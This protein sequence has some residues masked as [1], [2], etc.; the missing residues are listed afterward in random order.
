MLKGLIK[1]SFSD[2]IVIV[3]G[4]RTPIGSFMGRL[5]TYHAADLGS[6]AI[7]GSLLAAKVSKEEVDEVIMG[8]VLSSGLGQAPARQAAIRAGL[9]PSVICTTINK[10]CASGMKS[11]HFGSLSIL[12]GDSKVVVAGG[13]ESMSLVPHYLYI[14]KA[15]PWGEP[16]MVDGIMFDGLTDSFN[17]I[18]MGN[19]AE[20][21]NRDLNITRQEQDDFAILSYERSISAN[22]AGLLAKEIVPL[23]L[24][25][26]KGKQETIGEDE[27]ISRFLRDKIPNLKPVFEKNGTI[28]AANA[29]KNADGGCALVL[30]SE[31]L[32]NEK[33]LKPIARIKGFADYEV[34]PI[35]FSIAPSSAIQKLLKKTG[36]ELKDI[37]YFE[38]N[39]AFAGTALCNIKL[40]GLNKDKVNVNGGAVS[41][42]HPI[43][44]S[45]ARI[46][47]SL[48]NVLQSNN[49]RYGVASICNGGGGASSICIERI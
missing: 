30:M 18:L 1:K 2:S 31:K 37:D 6:A 23:I 42:G 43:G 38:I 35:D 11:I 26:K 44:M 39:E 46:I 5:S 4:K 20:K 19:C 14:R 34:N 16:Q 24:Q 28:T 48:I 8:N 29:S 10:V 36:L 25:D 27:E 45:G 15:F 3:N 12:S 17:K 7:E 22:K 9:S 40:L 32:A 13:F 49:G 41:L 33:H 21:T 47:L